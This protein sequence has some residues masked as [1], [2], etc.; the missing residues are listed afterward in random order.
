MTTPKICCFTGYSPSKLPFKNDE[1][2]IACVNLKILIYR[3]TEAAIK[4]GY[5]HF[6]CGFALGS[7]TYFA[8]T[9][10]GLR[11][12]YP[13]ITLEAALA[14][15][16]QAEHWPERDRDRYF[17]LLDK[18]D[19]ETFVSRSYYKGCYLDRNSYIVNQAQRLIAVFDDQ[20]S[21]TMVTISKAKAKK[22]ELVIINPST[23]QI[24]SES[25]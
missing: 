19:R 15:E 14:C 16:T 24:D 11:D 13:E 5:T 17:G 20:F 6:I 21:G 18:C 25:L 8:E 2:S 23:L 7:D 22:L 4:D 10:I 12:R 3:E 1:N 9:V